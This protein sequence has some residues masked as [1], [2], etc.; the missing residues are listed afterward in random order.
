MDLSALS[1]EELVEKLVSLRGRERES[2]LAILYH[3]IELDNRSLYRE[4]GYSSL[5]DYCVRAL[6]YSEPSSSRRVAAAR[7]LRDNPELC[8]LFLEGKVTL[9][10]I[11]T[12]AKGL[13]EKRTEVSEIV[14]KSKREVELLVA[15]VVPV[16]KERIRPVVLE[17]PMAPLL[18]QAK[19]EERYTITFSVSKEVYERYEQ[20]KNLLS[21]KLGS[22]LSVE[23]IFTELIQRQL[24]TK[25]SKV[26][27]SPLKR[28]RHIRKNLKHEIRVR[29]NHQCTYISP[30][31]VRC[32]AKRYLQF[33]HIVPWAMGGN[34]DS[35]NLRLRCS[36][37]NQLHAEQSF[38]KE[39]MSTFTGERKM[40]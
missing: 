8:E 4:L 17:A 2:T 19:R 13:R 34:T 40:L 5:F 6:K 23:A 24:S 25:T 10:T 9:C 33:D 16:L 15:P 36:C 22:N 26:Q 3:L 37:H 14:C 30:D 32:S 31:G 12:A 21:G 7:T 38:G 29:D 20:V 18:P 35:S 39:F 27:N 28:T 1:N 11:A